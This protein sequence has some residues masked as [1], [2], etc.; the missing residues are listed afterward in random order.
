MRPLKRDAHPRKASENV[1]TKNVDHLQ[2][3]VAD[4]GFQE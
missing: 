4:N 3:V 2:T 1:D